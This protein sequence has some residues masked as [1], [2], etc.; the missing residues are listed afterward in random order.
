MRER[1]M[2]WIA[3]ANAPERVHPR[4]RTILNYLLAYLLF[5]LLAF[6]AVLLTL[7][8]HS[9][10]VH[11]CMRLGMWQPATYGV[12][13][14]GGFLLFIAYVVFVALLEP[15]LNRA[16]KEGHVLRT[17]LYAFGL[18]LGIWALI[19]ILNLVR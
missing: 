18:L 6:A 8:L 1:L 15:R 9:A 5:C 13:V 4:L 14:W 7:D 10:V 16:A 12:Y 11:L 19:F 3:P 17:G 2:R